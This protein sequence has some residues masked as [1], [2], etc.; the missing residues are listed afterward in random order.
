MKKLVLTGCSIL[1]TLS[2]VAQKKTRKAVFIIVDGIAADIIERENL[3]ALKAI[4]SQGAYYRAWLGGEKGG[5]SQTPTI[6]AVGYNSVLTGTWAN[7]HNVWGNG[8]E[9][10]NYFFPTIFRLLKN[11]YPQKKI[12]IFSSWLDN[13]TKLVGDGLAATGFIKAD[14][15]ADGFELDTIRFPHDKEHR[16]MERIDQAVAQAAA[17][18]IT[19]YG[20]DL[21]WVYM[22]YTDDMGHMHGDH[23]EYF[24][25][26]REMDQKIGLIWNAIKERE[27]K[28]GEEW[29]IYITTDHGRDAATGKGHGGQSYRERNIWIVTNKAGDNT[30]SKFFKPANTDI[31]PSIAH[32][33]SIQ[34]PVEVKRELDGQSLLGPSVI[35][36]MQVNYFQEKIDVS[37]TALD[38]NAE[39]KILVSTTNNFKTGKA[40][41]Y[42]ELARVPAGKGSY[43]LD[44][45]GLPSEFYKVVLETHGTTLNRW[46]ELTPKKE[47]ASTD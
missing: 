32:F 30:Y 25:A 9:A 26:V 22:Q 10:P 44:V 28:L 46:I 8:I 11:Q 15:V 2:L 14:Y 31:L 29:L 1:L 47:K 42:K 35:T 33:L 40:D 17:N 43:I 41:E 5:Y 7:K 23:P 19:Q 38:K 45:S 16:Y 36:N 6:S 13:R 39:V 27:K 20:P 34:L 24:K 3:P 37:W 18:H 21:S 12:G 4:S